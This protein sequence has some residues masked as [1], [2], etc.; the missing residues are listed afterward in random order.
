MKAL[1][2]DIIREEIRNEVRPLV[3]NYFASLL[4]LEKGVTVV[5][6]HAGVTRKGLTKA[7]R[8][9]KVSQLADM[10]VGKKYFFKTPKN[11]DVERWADRWSST[12]AYLQRRTGFKWS[13]HRDHDQGGAVIVRTR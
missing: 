10:E 12:I 4:E 6:V 5:Q 8:K 13:T 3:K 11:V 7:V 2:E 9:T 1:V